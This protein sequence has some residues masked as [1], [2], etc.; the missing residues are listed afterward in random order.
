MRNKL[1][2]WLIKKAEEDQRIVLIT[3]DLGFS[4]VEE[5]SN[6]FPDRFFN[7]GVAEQVAYEKRHVAST[8]C[9]C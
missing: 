6:K 9:C 5:F 3:A 8:G 1:I 2:H 7:A 4:V